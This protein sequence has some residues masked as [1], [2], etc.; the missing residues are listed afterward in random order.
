MKYRTKTFNECNLDFLAWYLLSIMLAGLI[1]AGVWHT[2]WEYN[3]KFILAVPLIWF[4]IFSFIFWARYRVEQHARYLGCFSTHF[5]IMNP[6]TARDHKYTYFVQDAYGRQLVMTECVNMKEIEII[7]CD[8]SP[9]FPKLF[10]A[11]LI[12]DLRSHGTNYKIGVDGNRVTLGL[13]KEIVG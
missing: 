13:T 2:D 12:R 7:R 10:Y 5:A 9:M 6:E 1:G 8:F 3:E 11:H 4:G